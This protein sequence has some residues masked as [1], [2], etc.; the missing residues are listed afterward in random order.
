[1]LNLKSSTVFC[2]ST[3]LSYLQYL[4]YNVFRDINQ[5]S[6]LVYFVHIFNSWSLTESIKVICMYYSSLDKKL[7]IHTIAVQYFV[8][9]RERPFRER[10]LD[11]KSTRL[12][13]SF[14]LSDTR[15]SR[16]VRCRSTYSLLFDLKTAPGVA[17]DTKSTNP[18]SCPW[19]AVQC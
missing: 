11:T 4:Y 18:G 16:Y 10:P 1:M 12:K 8:S 9:S 2:H 15:S 14:P 19:L 6:N 5:S 7:P 13:C 3:R 17:L